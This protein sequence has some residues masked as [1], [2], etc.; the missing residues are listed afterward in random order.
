VKTD[1]SRK[2]SG[3]DAD[4]GALMFLRS[5]ISGGIIPILF[6][7]PPQHETSCCAELNWRYA[8]LVISDG[9]PMVGKFWVNTCNDRII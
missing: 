5:P 1:E 7:N 8:G 9:I 4:V 3:K 6:I 2:F